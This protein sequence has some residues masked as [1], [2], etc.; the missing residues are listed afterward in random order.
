MSWQ[1][2][3]LPPTSPKTRD[4]K[5]TPILQCILPGKARYS[6]HATTG[7]SDFAVVKGIHCTN[8]PLLSII[9]GP[10]TR[11]IKTDVFYGER[12]H[13][14][15]PGCMVLLGPGNLG[16]APTLSLPPTDPNTDLAFDQLRDFVLSTGPREMS[17]LC[18]RTCSSG[19]KCPESRKGTEQR[20]KVHFSR[21]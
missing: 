1:F 10:E 7:D 6:S 4:N 18:S 5:G 2:R 11:L 13:L 19:F 15:G 12:S 20:C 9:H 17:W 14:Q 3:S 16:D 8:H 21:K